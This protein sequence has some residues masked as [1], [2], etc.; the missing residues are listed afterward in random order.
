TGVPLT[1]V[2]HATTGRADYFGALVNRAARLMAGAKAGQILLDKTA[3]LEVL[4]EWR[5]AVSDAALAAAAAGT[6]TLR[7][8][9]DHVNSLSSEADLLSAPIATTTSAPGIMPLSSLP[10]T[11]A[12]PAAANLNAAGAPDDL[13]E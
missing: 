3:G 1:V 11:A 5:Q 10:S 6:A 8:C 2:P 13:Q 9:Q 12:S 4:G 7:P